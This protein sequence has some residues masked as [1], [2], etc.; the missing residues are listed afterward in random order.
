MEKIYFNGNILTINENN[1]K[2]SAIAIANGKIAAVGNDDSILALKGANTEVI[3]LQG[4]T[5]LP[6]FIDA[7]SHL[8]QTGLRFATEANLNSPVLGPIKC[9]DDIINT[10]K[11]RAAK[12]PKGKLIKG[13]GYDDTSLAEKRRVTKY[14]LD[15]VST[16]HPVIIRHISGHL[17]GLNSK[18]LELLEIYEDTPDPS[19][20]IYCRDPETG[21]HNGVIEEAL[22]KI[23][24]V[25][26]SVSK[27]DE[28][29]AIE[30]GNIVY[31]S[32]G[33]TLA[34]TGATR[35][36]RE[37]DLLKQGQEKGVMKIRVLLNRAEITLESLKDFQGYDEMF[38]KGTG[39]TFQDGSI[40]G[41]TGYLREPYHVPFQGDKS[42]RGY[43]IRPVADLIKIVE[44]FH[45]Q[46]DQMQIHCNGDQAIEDVL[47]AIEDVQ[48][49]YPHEDMRHIAVHAQMTREDQLDR[50]QKLGVIPSF[51]VLHPY[52]WGDRHRD[53]F[54]GPERAARMSPLKSALDRGMKFT[55]HCDTPVVPQEPLRLIWGAVNRL[56]SSG[57]VIGEA[58][59]IDV[60]NA[61]KA[62]TIN[63][64]YQYKLEDKMGSIETGKFADL[65]ILSE[66]ITQMESEKIKDAFVLETIV[67]GETIYKA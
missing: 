48:K 41:Y 43:P 40:Q 46:G 7:H 56:S 54:M 63:A 65:V 67:N 50:M 21:E 9:I 51:F 49:R 17:H 14:D 66:D 30:K 20:G 19:D 42:Y 2:V 5:M 37:V 53:I 16:E 31:S 26:A 28:E 58:Q 34:S 23:N 52:Y 1:D 11:E 29:E 24:L 38:Y 32:V 3:D 64:A 6:G 60:W 45:T 39:K 59:R 8:F 25:L 36:K 35:S 33:V 55:I 57:K 27:E 62:I 10:L 47:D 13:Y 15:K 44:K 12:A 4:K 22:D 18:A 61:I